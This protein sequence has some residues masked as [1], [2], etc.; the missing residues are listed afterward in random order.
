MPAVLDIQGFVHHLVERKGVLGCTGPLVLWTEF[1][2]DS[3]FGEKYRPSKLTALYPDLCVSLTKTSQGCCCSLNVLFMI[4]LCEVNSMI[5]YSK[6]FKNSYTILSYIKH[7]CVAFQKYHII[8]VG[9][10]VHGYALGCSDCICSLKMTGNVHMD[11][12]RAKWLRFDM[13]LRKKQHSEA[14]CELAKSNYIDM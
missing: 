1:I 9:R 2:G 11:W 13:A 5:V 8:Y 3:Y 6:I 12:T 7:F 14:A 4:F 10:W